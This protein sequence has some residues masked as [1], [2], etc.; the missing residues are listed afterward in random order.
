MILRQH[1]YHDNKG[2]NESSDLNFELGKSQNITFTGVSIAS[3]ASILRRARDTTTP[4]A[5]DEPPSGCP[6]SPA[7]FLP[8]CFN[9]LIDVL[10]LVKPCPDTSPEDV[11]LN[12]ESETRLGTSLAMGEL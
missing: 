6:G 8:E 12:D 1:T 7:P 11:P 2:F 9:E 4:R 5:P 3:G 10:C